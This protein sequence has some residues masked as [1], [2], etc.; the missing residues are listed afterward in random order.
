[1]CLVTSMLGS[2]C[3]MACRSAWVWGG[4]RCSWLMIGKS[5]NR[6]SRSPT[7]PLDDTPTPPLEEAASD[8]AGLYTHKGGQA[9]KQYLRGN[10]VRPM[11][12]G[13]GYIRCGGCYLS[14]AVCC[15]GCGGTSPR[16]VSRLSTRPF[17][18][19]C[20]PHTIITHPSHLHHTAMS[21]ATPVSHPHTDPAS[22]MCAPV[23]VR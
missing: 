20:T 23:P 6:S 7:P 22:T 4:V 17:M 21:P 13:S 3:A 15:G 19:P 11:Q 16:S 10:V 12:K 9:G 18:S 1:M 2:C 14:A 8:T 5:S